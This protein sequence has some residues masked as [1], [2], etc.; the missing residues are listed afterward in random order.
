MEEACKISSEVRAENKKAEERL[1][2]KCRWE[3]M[4]RTAVIREWG[5]P[6]NWK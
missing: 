1:A 6:R 2:A 5:D 3:R 4:S